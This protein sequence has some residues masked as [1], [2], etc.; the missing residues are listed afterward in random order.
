MIA[1]NQTICEQNQLQ[2]QKLEKLANIENNTYN[3][4][5]YAEIAAKNAEAA[6]WIGLAN[7]IGK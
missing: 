2:L 5:Q 3:A 1:Q 6:A 4:A 7:Y